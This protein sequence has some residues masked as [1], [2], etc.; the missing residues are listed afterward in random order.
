M[1][2]PE[3]DLQRGVVQLL[4]LALP[5]YLV[6]HVP[7]GGARTPAEAAIL[8]GLGVLPGVADLLVLGEGFAGGLE[9]KAGKGKQSPAQLRFEADCARL[10]IPYAVGRS[11]EDAERIVR[12]WGL[13][14]R[15]RVG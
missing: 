8:K 11:L 5:R 10:R 9:L 2:R 1:N 6:L 12:S 3:Q 13:E 15:A 14:V 7:N 4:R